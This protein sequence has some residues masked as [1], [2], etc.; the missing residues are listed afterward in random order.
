LRNLGSDEIEKIEG[1]LAPLKAKISLKAIAVYGSQVSGYPREESDYDIILVAN[2]FAQRIKYYYLRGQVQC[3]ALVV[4]E[5]SF[6]NDCAKSSLGE[7]VSGRLLNP[8]EALLGQDFLSE[9][10]TTYKQRVILEGLSEAYAEN[11][12]FAED[13]DFPLDYF[14]FEKL[15]KRAAIYPPVVYSYA[16]TYG[17]DLR[18]ANLQSSLLGFRSAAEK[19]RDADLVNY[20]PE[21][22]ILKIRPEK[23]KGGLGVRL[24]ST[25]SYTTRGIRQYAIHGYAGRV[26]LDVVAREVASKLGR[27]RKEHSELP[28]EIATP[29]ILW[30]LKQCKLFAASSDWLSDLLDYFGLNKVSTIVTKKALGEIYNSTNFY[31]LLENSGG[32]SLSIAVKRYNDIKGIKWGLLNVWSLKNTNFST[33][34]NERMYREFRAIQQ[35]KDLGLS[36]PE[37]LAVF[38]SE[39]ILVTRYIQGKD[40]SSIQSAYLQGD[41]EDLSAQRE[42]GM[43]LARVHRAGSCIGD[44]KPSNVIVAGP[45]SN[46]YLTDLEQVHSNGNLAWDIA[47]FIYYSARF[48]LKEDRA[49]KLVNE[50]TSGY[51]D[52][53][54][55]SR[56]IEQTAALRYRA[57][58]QAFIA[59]NVL[60]ALRKDLAR[61]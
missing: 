14:L 6:A 42:F 46:L 25:A 38:L 32:R 13:I 44:T 8:Y 17:D 50:F 43:I 56:I 54:G 9:N 12:R 61:A 55:D 34:S 2:R 23:M 7:F 11:G 58:F 20:D 10:E 1:T 37:I 47:E 3:S 30:S 49:R 27:A 26:G 16:L 22:G 53:G 4:Q 29:K 60:N 59:P 40:L 41:S 33:N 15:R 51:R 45:N 39:K 36:T 48:T 35:F 19:L 57:P 21:N 52:G 28:D 18:E 31:T 5:K 24:S